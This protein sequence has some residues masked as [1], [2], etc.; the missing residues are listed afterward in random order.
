MKAKELRHRLKIYKKMQSKN[1]FQELDYDEVVFIKEIFASCK[2][3]I[4]ENKE[5]GNITNK[6]SFCEFEVRFLELDMS[7][8]I[9]FEGD[10]YEIL[11]IQD[12]GMSKRFLKIKARK[13]DDYN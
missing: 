6:T 3:L 1:E 10:R 9:E 5:Q 2:N 13:I 8:L 7:Y 4:V 12:E 11:S